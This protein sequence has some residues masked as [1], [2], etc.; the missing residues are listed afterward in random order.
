MNET[1]LSSSAAHLFELLAG[2]TLTPGQNAA[3][4][5]LGEFLDEDEH[6]VFLLKGYAGT[7]KTFLID[8]LVKLLRHQRRSAFLSAPTGRAARIIT[9]KTGQTATTIHSLIYDFDDIEELKTE[10]V[11]GSETYKVIV[12]LGVNDAPIDS[13]FV[14]DEASLISD[15]YSDAEFF[16][17]GSGFLLRDLM[18]FI[19]FDNNRHRKKLILIGD[20]AQLPPV[21]M[22]FSPA[23]SPD[24]LR[25]AFG[26][27]I[28][29][30]ELSDVVRQKAE[31]GILKNVQPLR[32]SL[33]SDTFSKLSFETSLPD[34]SEIALPDLVPTFLASCNYKVNNRAVVITR[35]NAEAGRFNRSIREQ[36]FPGMPEAA[37][38]DKLMVVKNTK[39]QGLRISNG[40]FALVRSVSD[41]RKTRTVRIRRK[42]EE[43]SQVEEISV[44]LAFREVEIGLRLIDGS[45][46]FLT[47]NII[48]NLLYADGP[49]LTSDEHKALYIDFKQRHGHLRRDR[50]AFSQAMLEDPYFNALR[51]KFG[52]ALTCHKA[53]GSEWETAFVSCAC[54]GNPLSRDNFRWLY[55]ALTRARSRLYLLDPPRLAVGSG[56][57]VAGG[58]GH[59][60]FAAPQEFPIEKASSVGSRPSGAETLLAPTDDVAQAPSGGISQ[61]MFNAVREALAGTDFAIEALEHYQYQEA[62]FIRRGTE[63]ARI[64]ISYNGR[65]RIA[66]VLAVRDDDISADL[67]AALSGLVGEPLLVAPSAGSEAPSAAVHRPGP[68]F[69]HPFL[70]EFHI[71]LLALTQPHGIEVTG[72]DQKQW[73]QRY[74]FQS[75][76]QQTQVDVFYN[77]RNVFAKCQPVGH[78]AEPSALLRKVMEILTVEMSR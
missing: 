42:N 66:R 29:E 53:Q 73:C 24:Y 58:L 22:S 77:G 14:T 69:V 76:G 40:D 63:R 30:I 60:F 62:Y 51:V 67:V 18:H 12:S 16:Q 44:E 50:A 20:D 17:F 78:V 52:Y 43:T 45:A 64:N 25:K 74:S 10:G 9:E 21:G 4:L 6:D 15:Q 49:Q 55:T 75:G 5:A 1:A 56:I 7:G 70:E 28:R 26:V 59:G 35:S 48:E 47:A 13:V 3:V 65:G 39:I 34:V 46:A 32:Q 72:L 36:L 8:A 2:F 27:R 54:L 38:G 61:A 57:K 37:A 31:S 19:N 68:R 71:K 33:K 41:E 23:L 11:E